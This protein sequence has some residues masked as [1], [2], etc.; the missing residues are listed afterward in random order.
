[1]LPVWTSTDRNGTEWVSFRLRND[2]GNG[3]T[4]YSDRRARRFRMTLRL[5]YGFEEVENLQ[6]IP[7][8]R[9]AWFKNP[10]L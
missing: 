8:W 5:H 1:M 9:R 10:L 3:H 4:T 6:A 2:I 7:K